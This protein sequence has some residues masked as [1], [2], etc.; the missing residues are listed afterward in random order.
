MGY[1]PAALPI[2]S[3]ALPEPPRGNAISGSFWLLG[4]GGRRDFALGVPLGD[5][6]AGLRVDFSVTS[7]LSVTASAYAPLQ[8]VRG[9]TASV[10]VRIRRGAVGAIVERR[11]P[12]DRGSTR[13]TVL[14]AYAGAYDVALPLRFRLDGYAQAGLVDDKGFVQGALGVER[15]VVS[16]GRGSLSAGA[17]VWAAAEPRVRRLD[18]GPQLVARVPVGTNTVRIGAEWRERV[19][20]NATPASGPSVS[21]GLDF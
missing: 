5:A 17:A 21:I 11:V 19:H 16:L 9:R 14:T 3:V 8:S 18:L 7:A 6:Q 1:A 12:L 13:A 10:G 20:G 15:R 2:T 4:R